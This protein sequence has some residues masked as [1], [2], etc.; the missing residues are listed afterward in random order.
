MES[1]EKDASLTSAAE[2]CNRG[3]AKQ[4]GGSAAVSTQSLPSQIKNIITIPK[5]TGSNVGGLGILDLESTAVIE[6][7]D[8]KVDESERKSCCAMPKFPHVIRQKEFDQLVE[9]LL[10]IFYTQLKQSFPAQL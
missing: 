5:A 6:L 4:T 8:S 10:G 7:M 2:S 9:K 1:R 3:K